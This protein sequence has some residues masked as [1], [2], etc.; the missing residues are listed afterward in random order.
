MKSLSVVALSQAHAGHALHRWWL[1]GNVL[2]LEDIQQLTCEVDFICSNVDVHIE[3]VLLLNDIPASSRAADALQKLH[4]VC[5]AAVMYL[6]SQSNLE[7][8]EMLHLGTPYQLC[9]RQLLVQKENG[10]A[11]KSARVWYGA[12]FQSQLSLMKVWAYP[13]RRDRHHSSQVLEPQLPQGLLVYL[14]PREKHHG[15]LQVSSAGS[16]IF[17]C[18]VSPTLCKLLQGQAC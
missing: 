11:L 5:C 9:K 16:G 2:Y 13:E 1:H 10:A 18:H 6:H 17:R 12:P 15:H 7:E 14:T 4:L 8:D 3:E